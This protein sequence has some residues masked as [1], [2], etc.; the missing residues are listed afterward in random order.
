MKAKSV[1]LVLVATFFTAAAQFSF[2]LGAVYETPVNALIVTGF[3]SYAVSALLFIY[4]LRGGDLS[5]LYPFWSLSFVWIFLVSSFLLHESVNIYNWAG[6]FMI[7][8]GVS[9]IGRGE[10]NG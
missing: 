3:L 1:L 10:K 8:L 5:V 2:K 7:I 6:V 4:A 9:V